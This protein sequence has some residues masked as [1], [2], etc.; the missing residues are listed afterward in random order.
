MPLN[1]TLCG[2]ASSL[3]VRLLNA[4]SVGGS[5]T[6]LTVSGKTVLA[7]LPLVFETEMVISVEPNWSGAGDTVTVRFVPL[8][9]KMMFGLGTS[10]GLDELPLRT[11]LAAGGNASR[12]AKPIGGLVA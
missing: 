8:I 4:L 9:P 12:T 11:R 2:P 5:F 1:R 3:R 10:A 6:G 7:M